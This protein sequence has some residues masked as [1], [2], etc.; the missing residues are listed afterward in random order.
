MWWSSAGKWEKRQ[1]QAFHWRAWRTPSLGPVGELQ[2]PGNWLGMRSCS[3]QEPSLWPSSSLA[4]GLEEWW[5]S[6]PS[7]TLQPTSSGHLPGPQ[8][9]RTCILTWT[10]WG[11]RTYWVGCQAPSRMR[12]G[13]N[14]GTLPLKSCQMR[15]LYAYPGWDISCERCALRLCSLLTGQEW[16]K[17][18]FIW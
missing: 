18:T 3:A 5:T 2:V 7:L 4:P 9:L 12:A 6:P 15:S 17:I 10:A 16:Q 13:Q 8:S 14:V 11:D 1:F